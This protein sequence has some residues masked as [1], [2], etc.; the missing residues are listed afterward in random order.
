[1]IVQPYPESGGDCLFGTFGGF[2]G[3]RFFFF[4]EFPPLFSSNST[5]LSSGFCV[6][7]KTNGELV[8]AGKKAGLFI[9]GST[10]SDGPQAAFA[11]WKTS[12][13]SLI[14]SSLISDI[15]DSDPSGCFLGFFKLDG[16]LAGSS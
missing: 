5:G 7:G 8:S 4:S 15:S 16:F 6:D 1:M 9:P 3:F 11:C 13:D 10:F 2:F 14:F 12:L